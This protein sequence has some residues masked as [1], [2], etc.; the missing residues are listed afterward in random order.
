M[1]IHKHHMYILLIEIHITIPIFTLSNLVHEPR[2]LL[3]GPLH[4]KEACF[5]Q[6]LD[7]LLG[8]QSKPS[9]RI[10]DNLITIGGSLYYPEAMLLFINLDLCL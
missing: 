8:I 6:I 4:C 10:G 5:H 2:H 3:G 7:A 1:N 9:A